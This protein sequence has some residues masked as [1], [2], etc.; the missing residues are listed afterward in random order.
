MSRKFTAV[1]IFSGAGGMSI[2]SVMAGLDPIL[3]IEFDVHAAKTYETNH[4][5]TKVLQKDIKTV[6]PLDTTEKYPFILFG[7]PPCQ[8]FSAA[9]TKTRNLKNP[10]NWMYKEY[11]R[12]VKDLEPEWFLFENVI[13]FRSFGK[14]KFAIE[15]E[16]ELKS[17]G[18]ETSSTVLNAANFGVPQDRKRFFIVG[19][20]I[21]KGG[22]KF[23]FSTLRREKIVS[24]GEALADLPSLN[25]GDK[26]EEH[27]YMER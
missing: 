15:V 10:N 3:A 1:D 26:I 6:N 9:N 27:S 14:G 4:P 25:N 19:H 12:F 7:G 18:Y 2:G 24:V 23:D 13:G 16:E 8:G 5:K 20:R 17:L 11:L 22:V 21:D